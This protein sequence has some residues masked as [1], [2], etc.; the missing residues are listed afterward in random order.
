[1]SPSIPSHLIDTVGSAAASTRDAAGGLLHDAVS[2]VRKRR[3]RSKV[4]TPAITALCAVLAFGVVVLIGRRFGSAS[5]G[6]GSMLIKSADDRPT[7]SPGTN[8]H[9][10]NGHST[11]N[12]RNGSMTQHSDDLKGRVKEAAGALTDNDELQSEGKRDQQA[13]KA[14]DAVDKARDAVND[15]IDS[16]KDKLSKG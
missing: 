10:S 2:A 7:D 14:K 15:G 5:P 3:H 11:T 12:E 6:D 1:M 8:G 16:V 13:G 9:T 4:R